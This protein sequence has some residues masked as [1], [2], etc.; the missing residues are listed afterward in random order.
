MDPK[1]D[2]RWAQKSPFPADFCTKIGQNIEKIRNVMVVTLTHKWRLFIENV[3]RKMIDFWMKYA[4]LTIGY[5][6]H[7]YNSLTISKC[8]FKLTTFLS[9]NEMWKPFLYRKSMRKGQ[10]TWEWKRLNGSRRIPWLVDHYEW[11]CSQ[12]ARASLCRSRIGVSQNGKKADN[13]SSSLVFQ[14]AYSLLEVYY[15]LDQQDLGRGSRINE[16][17]GTSSVEWE[18]RRRQLADR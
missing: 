9:F 15:L 10:F 1:D 8:F 16:T 13:Q 18:D 12:Q 14:D 17:I 6:L 3:Y 2:Q 11:M 4:Y 7:S 5:T